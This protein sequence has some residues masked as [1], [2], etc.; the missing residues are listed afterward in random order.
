MVRFFLVVSTSGARE[1]FFWERIEESVLLTFVRLE[2]AET[3]LCGDCEVVTLSVNSVMTTNAIKKPMAIVRCE[4]RVR[5]PGIVLSIRLNSI[6]RRSFCRVD[7]LARCGSRIHD[8]RKPTIN[9][10]TGSD[11]V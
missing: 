3:L 1:S 9:A 2:T 5:T 11:A 7:K 10:K 4:P 6:G 8:P